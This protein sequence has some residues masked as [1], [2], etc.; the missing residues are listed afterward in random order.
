MQ[1]TSYNT[2]AFSVN[3]GANQTWYFYVQAQFD[4]TGT[5]PT[6]QATVNIVSSG[7]Q[8]IGGLIN[9]V[10]GYVGLPIVQSGTTPFA[11]TGTVQGVPRQGIHV[12]GVRSRGVVGH[13]GAC[14][15]GACRDAGQHEHLDAAKRQQSTLRGVQASLMF[16]PGLNPLA[17]DRQP[18]E[19]LE[20]R[21]IEG[22]IPTGYVATADSSVFPVSNHFVKTGGI[23]IYIR[24]LPIPKG[25]FM[26]GHT[27]AIRN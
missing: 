8:V 15:G 23:G 10:G 19:A 22:D 14:A 7:G 26:S 11:V 3:V 9:S 6:W 12:S 2:G 18:F 16:F 5:A 21:V 17:R 4:Y 20:R 27:G 25:V 24:E 13:D 1:G